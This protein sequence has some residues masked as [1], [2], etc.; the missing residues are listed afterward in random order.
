MRM[1]P[2]GRGGGSA[3][4]LFLFS[5]LD[6]H[7]LIFFICFVFYNILKAM[8]MGPLGRRGVSITICLLLGGGFDFEIQTGQWGSP[9]KW[10]IYQQ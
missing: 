10:P 9:N 6:Y 5:F 8:G 3:E 4:Y 2:L 1:G 7:R